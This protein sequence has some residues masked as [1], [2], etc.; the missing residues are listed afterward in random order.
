MSNENMQY[1]HLWDDVCTRIKNSGKIHDVMFRTWIEPIE[2]VKFGKD[3]LFLWV[4]NF[5]NRNSIEQRYT[6]IIKDAVFKVLKKNYEIKVLLR[7]EEEPVEE[8]AKPVKTVSFSDETD[9]SGINKNFTFDTFI[10]GNSNRFAHAYSL[11]VAEAP[12]SDKKMNPL[13]LYGGAGL[14]KT[15]LCHAIGNFAKLLNPDANVIFISSQQYTIDFI[16]SL[17]EKTTDLFREKY[18]NADILI[19][20]DIQFIEGK[21]STIEEFFYTFNQLTEHSKQI[22]ITSDRPPNELKDIEDRM[23]SRF[24]QGLTIDIAPPDFETKIAILKNKAQRDNVSFPDDVYI[25]IADNI[26]SNIRELEGALNK[27][28]A[29]SSINEGELDEFTL[30]RLLKDMVI[31]VDSESYTYDML[32]RA[33]CKYFHISASDLKGKSKRKEIAYPRQ[34]CMYMCMTLVKNATSVDVGR[35][36]DKDHTTV[37]YAHNKIECDLKVNENLVS[38]IN[39]IKNLIE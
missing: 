4:P 10:V 19:V 20:D 22:V 12:G 6:D 25:Y 39:D 3:V 36:L 27:L 28:I 37:L 15:H 7:G 38:T 11:S 13:F 31:K 26:K 14:G 9:S 34:I 23:I 18:K 30:T 17:K 24:A 35:I 29:Y 5:V 8:K 2:K 1:E 32:I 33:V 21:H 16:N